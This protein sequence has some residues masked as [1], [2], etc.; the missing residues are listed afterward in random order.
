MLKCFKMKWN[1]IYLDRTTS[2]NDVA[3]SLPFLSVVVAREQTKG[4]GRYA[5]NWVSEPDNLFFSVVLKEFGVKT[6]LLSF[7]VA[8]SVAESLASLA[9][10]I[11]WPNDILIHG[12]K[13]A[14]ILLELFDD[15]VIVGIGINTMQMPKGDFVYPVGCLDG[16]VTNE[17]LLNNIL[18]NLSNNIKIFEENGFEKIREKWLGFALG[19]GEEIVVKLPKNIYEGIFEDMTNDGA[20]QLK[21]KDLSCKYITAGDVFLLNE[22]KNNE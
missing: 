2:T 4:R 6:H 15:K 1:L 11:K 12:K 9:A 18:N 8:I 7:V 22:G 19:L 14:G 21:M 5:R 20:I 17:I 10:K 13:V 3:K 16:A